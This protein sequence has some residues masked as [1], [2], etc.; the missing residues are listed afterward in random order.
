MLP[1]AIAVVTELGGPFLALCGFGA[2]AAVTRI[3]RP[4]RRSLRCVPTDDGMFFA[5]RKFTASE[6]RRD[7]SLAQHKAFLESNA[8]ALQ[9]SRGQLR[10][11]GIA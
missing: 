4:K 1:V 10:A 8:K 5:G 2:V 11:L 6:I 9:L 3:R 7:P